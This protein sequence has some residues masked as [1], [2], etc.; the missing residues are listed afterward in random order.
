MIVLLQ[1]HRI[2]FSSV[3]RFVSFLHIKR[4]RLLVTVVCIYCTNFNACIITPAL[5]HCKIERVSIRHYRITNCLHV[6]HAFCGVHLLRLF[7]RFRGGGGGHGRHRGG[8]CSGCR[9]RGQGG[10]CRGLRR[11][12]RGGLLRLGALFRFRGGGVVFSGYGAVGDGVPYFSLGSAGGVIKGLGIDGQSQG[13][14]Q[15]HDGQEGRQAAAQGTVG[16]A[17]LIHLLPSFLF[18]SV[19]LCM[20]VMLAGFCVSRRPDTSPADSTHYFTGRPVKYIPRGYYAQ[21]LRF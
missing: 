21:P 9:F 3:L 13:G 14:E 5:R 4:I 15:G 20:S 17:V 12:G 2:N 11:F 7:G 10:F 6:I 19:A 8:R 1:E 16:G 18:L